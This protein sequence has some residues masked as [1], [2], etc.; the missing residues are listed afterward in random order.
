MLFDTHAHLQDELIQEGLEQILSRAEQAGLERIACVGFDLPSSQ[1]AVQLARKYK[2]IVAL[3]GIH[4]HDAESLNEQAMEELYRLARDPQV[5]AIGEIGLDYY[6]DLSPKEAQHQ[7]FV[8]QIK[9]AQ[10]VGKPIAIHDRDA[11][12]DVMDIIKKEKAGKNNG[13]FHCFSGSLPMAV[14]MMKEGFYISFAGPVTFKNAKKAHEVAAKI[15]LDRILIETDCPYLTPE[16][17]RG[18]VNEPAH[19]EQVARKLAELRNKSYEEI[20]YLTTRNANQIY[21]L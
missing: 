19:V 15:P 2:Q 7:A 5:V 11:H 8:A 1:K 17:Y 4:P 6:R 18:Q 14:E 13:I 10:E 3:V 20:S 9:L 21:R 16:P 12:Q